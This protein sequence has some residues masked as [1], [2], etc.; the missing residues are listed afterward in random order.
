MDDLCPHCLCSGISALAD[1]TLLPLSK[2]GCG[3]ILVPFVP[4][5][6]SLVGSLVVHWVLYV[7]PPACCGPLLNVPMLCWAI[8]CVRTWFVAL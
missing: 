4:C 5:L 8:L 1:V 6:S 2:K 7:G 3:D